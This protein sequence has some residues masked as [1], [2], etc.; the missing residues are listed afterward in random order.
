MVRLLQHRAS[1]NQGFTLLELLVVVVIG[2]ILA[3]IAIPSFLSRASAAK[4][5]EARMYM[6][7]LNRTQQAFYVQYSRF[8]KSPEELGLSNQPANYYKYE[9]DVPSDGSLRVVHYAN[10]TSSKLRSYSGMV[11]LLKQGSV[12]A[13]ALCEALEPGSGSPPPLS[14]DDASISCGEGT[15]PLN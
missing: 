3:A 2:G 1:K 6:G 14:S 13:T 12:M 7:S 5:V 9:V 15:K 8:A 4:Q 10:P 11:A